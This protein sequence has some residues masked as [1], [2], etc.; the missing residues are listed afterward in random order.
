MP[1]PTLFET[2][3]FAV[4]DGPGV[5]T[6]LF[7]KG[8][9]LRCRWCHNPEGMESQ[10]Q[11]AYHEHKCRHCGECV[12][13]CR[14]H[15]HVMVDGVH[16]FNRAACIACG[17]CEVVCSGRALKRLGHPLTVET[18]RRLILADRDFYRDGGGATL[19]GGEPLLHPGFCADLFK[20][21]KADGIHC[22]LDTCGAVA[23]DAF[24]TV[25]PWTDMVLYDLKH[26]DDARHR[27][28]TGKSNRQII[29]NLRRLTT[30]GVPIEIRIP[31]IPAFNDDA[32]S[33]GAIGRVLNDLPNIVAVRLLP[34]H[35]AASKYHALGRADTMPNV[36]PP[37]PDRFETIAAQLAECTSLV[38]R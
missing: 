18:A 30:C 4:H 23:W 16:V 28:Y 8:C 27:A 34:Y 17:A 7:L 14:Q 19:S 2:R 13:A 22:A 11:L 36:D 25:L 26:A 32:D 15:A 6:V 1:T 31:I 35:R 12:A 21:L 29:E 20:R 37:S 38:V 24:A 5:R 33:I 9:P 10:P 3:R